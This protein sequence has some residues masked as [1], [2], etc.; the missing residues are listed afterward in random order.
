MYRRQLI[1]HAYLLAID[2]M[3]SSYMAEV[4]RAWANHGAGRPACQMVQ[5]FTLHGRGPEGARRASI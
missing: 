3:C 5:F 4:K 1:C 2:P